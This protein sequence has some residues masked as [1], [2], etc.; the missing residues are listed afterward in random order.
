MKPTQM[1]CVCGLVLVGLLDINTQQH[2]VL[3][4]LLSLA[5]AAVE[6]AAEEVAVLA[7]IKPHL[8]LPLILGQ[9]TRL[10]SVLVEQ[11]VQ[12]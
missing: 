10:L 6:V 1:L 3:N 12:D 4:I 2:L 11:K 9:H 5:V 7:D 8:D